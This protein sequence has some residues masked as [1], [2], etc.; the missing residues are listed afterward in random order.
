M[1]HH[2]PLHGGMYQM[3][4]NKQTLIHALMVLGGEEGIFD[5]MELLSGKLLD[6]IH[7]LGLESIL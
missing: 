5:M 1:K 2:L 3:Q 6:L 7:V 4:A